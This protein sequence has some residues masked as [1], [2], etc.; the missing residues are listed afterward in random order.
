MI[1]QILEIRKMAS[2][3]KEN[4]GK[5]AGGQVGSMFLD[6][7]VLPAL[8]V[9]GSLVIFFI[10]GFTHFLGGPYW[11]FKFLFFLTLAAVFLA[12]YLLRKIYLII[13]S[14]TKN[15]VESTIK[16]ESTIIE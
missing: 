4:P 15:V 2:E 11:F 12:F 7:L 5:F 13:K 6:L 8:V 3:A 10:F 1:F 9:F 14:V 16:V